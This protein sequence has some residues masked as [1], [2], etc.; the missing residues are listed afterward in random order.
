VGDTCSKF[1]SEK[2]R[3]TSLLFGDAGSALALEAGNS[4]GLSFHLGTDGSGFD[5]LIIPS[6]SFR[7]PQDEQTKIRHEDQGN[8]RSPEELYMDGGEIFNFTI[9]KVPTMLNSLLEF[10]KTQIEQI[11]Y[12][13]F[14]QAN[15]FMLNHLRKKAKIAPEKFL[16]S[17]EEYGNTS[18]ASIP[19]TLTTTLKTADKLK[20]KKIALFGFGVG[21][22]W[23]GTLLN[24]ND[25][26]Y[27]GHIEI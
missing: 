7:N 23:A 26:E 17:I 10:T 16:T 20:N 25:I 24:T 6:G 8:F 3:S 14:H 1:V 22:T 21:F 12:F 4:A 11:D 15:L 5:R 9:K 13:V 27:I 2:D 19:L 18:S